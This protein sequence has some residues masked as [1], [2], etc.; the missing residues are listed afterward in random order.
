MRVTNLG[1]PLDDEGRQ[2]S[3]LFRIGMKPCLEVSLSAVIGQETCSGG[4]GQMGSTYHAPLVAVG[5][6]RGIPCK[7]SAQS[8]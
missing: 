8:L 2:R 7:T 4:L 5:T 1:S 6:P 3:R